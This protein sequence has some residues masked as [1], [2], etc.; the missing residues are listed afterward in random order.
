MTVVQRTEFRCQA[1]KCSNERELCREDAYD[2]AEHDFT[3]ELE[4]GLSFTLHLGQGVSSRKKICEQVVVAIRSKS[5]VSYP[6]CGVVS[7]SQKLSPCFDVLPPRHD[8]ISETQ[9]D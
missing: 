8:T 1:P 4:T 7:A 3:R 9:I 6:A 5:E 2:D